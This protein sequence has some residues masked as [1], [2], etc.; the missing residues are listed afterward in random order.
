MGWLSA[1]NSR[2]PLDVAGKCIGSAGNR[3]MATFCVTLARSGTLAEMIEKRVGDW[4]QKPC[5][6]PVLII[7]PKAG[8]GTIPK[9]MWIVVESLLNAS[10]TVRRQGDC[11]VPAGYVCTGFCSV[12]STMPSF[13]KSQAH[14]VGLPADLSVK[15]AI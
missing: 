10:V 12:L 5:V 1:K 2:P 3:K 8:T 9:P 4:N 7:A 13:S 6:D 15:K 14:A 11:D